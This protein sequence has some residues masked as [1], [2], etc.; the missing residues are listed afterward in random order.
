MSYLTVEEL[1]KLRPKDKSSE[2]GGSRFLGST[3]PD[4]ALKYLKKDGVILECGSHLG[5]FTRILQERGFCNIHTLDFYD[6]LVFPEREK[7][8]FHEINFNKET[9]PYTQEYF[10]GVTCWGMVEHLENPFHFTREVHRVLKPGGIYIMALPNVFHIMSRLLFLK[11]GVFP[12]W[13]KNKNHIFILPRGV[14]EKTILRYFD[15]VETVY[16]KPAIHHPW[17]NW[18]SSWLPANEWFGNFIIYVLRW[19]PFIEISEKNS[20]AA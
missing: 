14:F 11:K 10:D 2:D 8:T 12:R 15:L 4:L 20:P 1:R 18:V 16:T 13:D 19:K 5:M 6:A 7:L 3:E 9:M 17:L